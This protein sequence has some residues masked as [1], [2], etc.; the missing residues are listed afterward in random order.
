MLGVVG[1]CAVGRT[2]VA[3]RPCWGG[4]AVDVPVLVLLGCVLGWHV[5]SRDFSEWKFG[6]VGG[7]GVAVSVGADA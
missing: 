1:R 3:A 5:P 6:C 7:D 4:W 2:V